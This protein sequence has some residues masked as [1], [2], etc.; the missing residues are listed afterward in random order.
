M[1]II[2]ALD[3]R[4]LFSSRTPVE[5][6]AHQTLETTDLVD[7]DGSFTGAYC[8]HLQGSDSPACYISSRFFA[9]CL[10]VALMMAVSI[11]EASVN[12]RETA[13]RSTPEG[14]FLS[15]G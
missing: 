11:P 9:L 12:F 14:S 10:F 15:E 2:L 3:L 1:Y 4:G 13:G 8:L 7:V 6:H 5:H